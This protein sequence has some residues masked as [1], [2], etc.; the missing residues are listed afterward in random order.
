MIR[1]HHIL[2]L[3]LIE[4]D[5]D[6]ASFRVI[7]VRF[8]GNFVFIFLVFGIVERDNAEGGWGS[9]EGDAFLEAGDGE[10]GAG[11]GIRAGYVSVVEV[12]HL[13]AVG[14]AAADY[15]VLPFAIVLKH[16]IE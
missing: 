2:V 11:C 15:A 1:W 3:I 5:G 16:I 7:K 8:D 6:A 12:H 4:S 10:D 14:A 13:E 9:S